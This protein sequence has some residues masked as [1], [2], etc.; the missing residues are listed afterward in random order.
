MKNLWVRWIGAA[1]LAVA[2]FAVCWATLQF[3]F[4]VDAPVALGWA[5]LPF[6]VIMA[7]GGFWADRASQDTRLQEDASQSTSPSHK[8]VRVNQTQHAGD[9]AQ[10][11]QVG[12]DY[13]AAKGE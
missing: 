11:L 12:R 5:I 6:S 1:V 3:G 9:H 13:K 4:G 7:L 10:Q 2:G 8:E